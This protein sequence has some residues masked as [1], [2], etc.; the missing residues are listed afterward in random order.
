VTGR[1][2]NV[3]FRAKS[4][5]LIIGILLHGPPSGYLRQ[6]ILIISTLTT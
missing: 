4:G 2:F 1:R 5:N 6:Q 3:V